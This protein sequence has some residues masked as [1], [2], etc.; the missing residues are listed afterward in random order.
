[1]PLAEKGA[2]GKGRQPLSPPQHAVTPSAISARLIGVLRDTGFCI[3]WFG[4]SSHGGNVGSEPQQTL[5]AGVELLDDLM[6]SHGFVYTPTAAGVGSGGSF[7][8]GQFRRGNRSLELHYRY[9]L[10]LV[11]YHVGKLALSHEDYMWSV[12]DGRWRSEYPGFSK[13]PLDDFRHLRADLEHHCIDF[14]AGSDAGFESHV[15]RA[16]M[17][18]KTTSRL[19]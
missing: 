6:R 8:S 1:M 3:Y 12:L 13:E 14:L 5:E 19:P 18:K 9:S 11:T 16:E 17:L 10:G 7:A 2:R 15:Q 4:D